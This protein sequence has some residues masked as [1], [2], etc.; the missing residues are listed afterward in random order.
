M[1]AGFIALLLL[2]SGSAVAAQWLERPTPDIP[3]TADGKPNMAA[4][5]PRTPDGKP[6]L[7][8]LW[9]K[10]SPKYARN[11]VSDLKPEDTARVAEFCPTLFVSGGESDGWYGDRW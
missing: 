10:I 11:I 8:G 4:P 1:K 6:D 2:S 7:S 5:A 9:A 3:R